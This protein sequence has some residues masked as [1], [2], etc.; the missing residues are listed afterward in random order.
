MATRQQHYVWRKHLEAWEDST[1]KV[2][3]SRNGKI[4]KTGS[5][6]IMKQRDF[7]SLDRITDSDVDF[8]EEMLRNSPQSLFVSHQSHIRLLRFIGGLNHAVRSSGQ[9]PDEARKIIRDFSIEAEENLHV[10]IEQQALPLLEQLRLESA[11]FLFDDDSAVIFFVFLCQQF[12]RTKVR[13][14]QIGELFRNAPGGQDRGHLSNIY[15]Y[16]LA[17]DLAYG[18]FVNRANR[19]V[20]FLRTVTD[21]QFI[22]G[23]QPI[24]NLYLPVN[25][26]PPDEFIFYFP[27]SPLLSLLLL[28]KDHG[29]TSHDAPPQIV[30]ILKNHIACNS[31][32]FLVA[33]KK[34]LVSES[35]PNH[36]SLNQYNGDRLIQEIM[37]QASS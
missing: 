27:L 4:F 15:C 30:K 24:V 36:L 25:D 3:T 1:G 29:L 2:W 11:D 16:C 20:I 31:E 37:S 10:Q 17:E 35:T 19:E 5:Q 22:T 26:D 34:K 32:E 14:D 33:N 13:R 8:L 9:F 23:D 12:L 18:L 7:Y 21:C 28:P 6:N